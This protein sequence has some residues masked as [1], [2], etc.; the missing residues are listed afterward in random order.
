MNRPPLTANA[1][2]RLEDDALVRGAGKFR[3]RPAPAQPGLCRVRALAACARPHRVDR[4][5]QARARR[6]G[7]VA[8]LTAADMKAAGI[9]H[10]GSHPPL[11]GRG[12]KELIQPFRPALAG[13]RVLHVGEAVAMV[14]AETLGAGAG[15]RRTGRRSNTRN[16]RRWSTRA[17][18]CKPS[19]P[20]L[21]P[22]APGNHRASTGRAWSTS[23]PT[24]ARSTR[25]SNRR[26]HVAR[27]TVRQP[28]H[29]RDVDGDARRH[30]A[31]RRRDRPLHA[32]RL[33]AE[34]RRACATRRRRCMGVR[35]TSCASSPK[36]SAA[37][38]A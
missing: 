15:R 19:A 33:L 10:R 7:V 11:A 14:V 37:P 28:A 12:G 4:H 29:R 26:A 30:R 36:M 16:C 13:D 9:E 5:R 24:S 31:L 32:A 8:V 17:R 20:Q 6:K 3:R 18:R 35:T 25:S 27:V 22:E 21:H 38:S 2:S 34:R 1:K 23:P